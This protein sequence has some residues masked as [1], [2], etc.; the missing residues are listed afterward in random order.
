MRD[1]GMTF[2]A[3]A[4]KLNEEGVRTLRGGSSWRVSSVQAA[5][6]YKRP[7]PRPKSSHLPASQAST[8]GEEVSGGIAG[9]SCRESVLASYL[10]SV[11]RT[12][13]L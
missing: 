6:G 13:R 8:A 9:T 11:R 5:C 7:P 12:S 10:S 4:E 3:V 2:R 1:L